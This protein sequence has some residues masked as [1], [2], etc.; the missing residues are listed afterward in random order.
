MAYRFR[1]RPFRALVPAALGLIAL[2]VVVAREAPEH[3]RVGLPPPNLAGLEPLFHLELGQDELLT[4][5]RELVREQGIDPDGML[6]G[7]WQRYDRKLL[8]RLRGAHGDA[9]VLDLADRGAPLVTWTVTFYRPLERA[10]HYAGMSVTFDRKGR[11]VGFARWRF[12]PNALRSPVPAGWRSQ[13]RAALARRLGIDPARL[14]RRSVTDFVGTELARADAVWQMAGLGLGSTH[15]VVQATRRQG[16]LNFSE[17]LIDLAARP[18]L[19][20]AGTTTAYWAAMLLAMAIAFG[21]GV[22]TRGGAEPP[23]SPGGERLAVTAGLGVAAAIC[24]V[25]GAAL[26][27]VGAPV[28][29]ASAAALLAVAAMAALLALLTAR[30]RRSAAPPGRWLRAALIATVP[31]SYVVMSIACTG[32][33]DVGCTRVCGL[34]RYTAAP[35]AVLSLV[36]AG[37]DPRFYGYAV[38]AAATALVPNCVCDNF[39]NHPWVGWLGASP[40]CYFFPFAVTLVAITGLRGLYPRLCLAAAAAGSVGAAAIGLSHQLLGFPW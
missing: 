22:C 31:L 36:A 10:A 12:D 34:L 6:S 26:F 13:T 38:L 7:V 16:V 25:E 8:D 28:Q 32:Y 9:A 23:P 37:R 35:L 11:V 4:R 5:A 21:V 20:R 17:E 2:I 1:Q 40:M 18:G 30:P 14:E 39:L 24:A 19:S 3:S 29:T 33:L 15:V 27:G